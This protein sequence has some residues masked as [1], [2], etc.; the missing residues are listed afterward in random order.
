RRNKL[1]KRPF[2][3]PWYPFVPLVAIAGGI[4]VL[5]SEIFNDPEG[6]LLFI[7]IVVVGL[8]VF[9]LVKKIDRRH[10]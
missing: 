4:F 5:I 2:S 8:P 10:E 3:T 6:V 1:V 7:G 9:Y